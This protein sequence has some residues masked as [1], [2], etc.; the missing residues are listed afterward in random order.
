VSALG[1]EDGADLEVGA[2]IEEF[3]RLG[4][5]VDLHLAEE[6]LRVAI[7]RRSGPRIVRKAFM[8]TDIVGS[9]TLAERLG[10]AS[11]E[12]LLEWHFQMIRAHVTAGGGEIVKTTGDGVFAAFD[13]AP[14]A[15][16][17]AAAIQRDLR[18][19]HD[20]SGVTLSV[21]I[22][23]NVAEAS[24][25]AGDYIGIGVHVAA[26]IGAIATGGQILVATDALAE[27]GERPAGPARTVSVKG[28]TAPV[29]VAAV[30]WS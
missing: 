23:L 2:A 26:R 21:R 5:K 7:E 16:D 28:V 22:G 14:A 24:Q 18:D 27:A 19:H 8:F 11:W 30:D 12:R 13:A 10:D 6:E 3:R 29:T 15:I 17:A 25:R 9:T 1:D 4:A 20:D